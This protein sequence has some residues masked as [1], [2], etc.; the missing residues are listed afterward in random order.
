MRTIKRE[1]ILDVAESLCEKNGS[2]EYRSIYWHDKDGLLNMVRKFRVNLAKGTKN[3]PRISANMAYVTVKGVCFKLI[4]GAWKCHGVGFRTIPMATL[5][6]VVYND[7][8]EI[9][10]VR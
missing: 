8:E 5:S 9:H 4:D 3:G 6:K 10:P 1:S 2:G 7:R